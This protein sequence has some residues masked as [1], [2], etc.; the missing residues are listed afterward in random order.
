MTSHFG[1]LLR[2]VPAPLDALEH[3]A[4][5]RQALPRDVVAR[6]VAIEFIARRQAPHHAQR[7][8]QHFAIADAVAATVDQRLERTR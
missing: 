2:D 8:D 1:C 7:G 6:A 4:V 5:E 3:K